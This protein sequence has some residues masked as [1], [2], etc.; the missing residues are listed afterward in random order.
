MFESFKYFYCLNML[1]KLQDTEK[2]RSLT[3]NLNSCIFAIPMP[4]PAILPLSFM[5]HNMEGLS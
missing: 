2:D 4:S 3:L 5:V 1:Y